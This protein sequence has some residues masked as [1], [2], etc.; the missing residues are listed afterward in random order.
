MKKFNIIYTILLCANLFGCDSFDKVK[1]LK[2]EVTYY[3][4]QYEFVSKQLRDAQEK[5]NKLNMDLEKSKN[6]HKKMLE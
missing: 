3:K 5:M 4:T 1:K 6:I 2:Q